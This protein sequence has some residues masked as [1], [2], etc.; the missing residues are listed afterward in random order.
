MAGV[1]NGDAALKEFQFT[2]AQFRVQTNK[3]ALNDTMRYLTTSRLVAH[4][5]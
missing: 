1:Y 4:K 2:A 5:A 3:K